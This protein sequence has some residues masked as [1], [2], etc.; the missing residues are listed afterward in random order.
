MARKTD[1]EKIDELVKITAVLG[2]RIDKIHDEL[3]EFKR[4][5]EEGRRRL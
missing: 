1:G 5:V 3:K 4:D 2:E